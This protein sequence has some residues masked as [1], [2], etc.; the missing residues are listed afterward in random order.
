MKKLFFLLLVVNL[1]IWLWGQREEL[2][3][4]TGTAQPDFGAIRVIDKAEL[5]AR[6]I[7]ATAERDAGPQWGM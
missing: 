5:A 1:V 6:I 4:A 2:R 3:R 7:R